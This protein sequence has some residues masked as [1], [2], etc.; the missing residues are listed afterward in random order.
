MYPNSLERC[1]ALEVQV[2]ASFWAILGNKSADF[3]G[4]PLASRK[5]LP[6][7]FIKKITNKHRNPCII[8]RSIVNQFKK[9]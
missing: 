2:I 8:P 1:I 5:Q 9:K 6:T 4:F 7:I 3:A